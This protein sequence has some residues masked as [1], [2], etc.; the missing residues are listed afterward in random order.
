MLECP[1]LARAVC[2]VCVQKKEVSEFGE[3]GRS[4]AA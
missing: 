3:I 1:L 4:E 2:L